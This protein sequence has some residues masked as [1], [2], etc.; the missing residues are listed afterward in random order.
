MNAQP[1]RFIVQSVVC[2]RGSEIS[3]P[4]VH[5]PYGVLVQ[6]K[7]RTVLLAKKGRHPTT[8]ERRFPAGT[9]WISN[10]D[11]EVRTKGA[12]TF[13]PYDDLF[14]A[15]RACSHTSNQ[16]GVDSKTAGTET[17]DLAR[18]INTSRKL[19]PFALRGRSLSECVR[20]GH[21][22][23]LHEEVV[24]LLQ[25]RDERKRDAASLL[26]GA[27]ETLVADALGRPNP[28]GSAMRIGGS[29]GML[30]KRND[31]VIL[32]GDIID[33]RAVVLHDYIDEFLRLSEALW[34]EIHESEHLQSKGRLWRL[35]D[36]AEKGSKKNAMPLERMR[37]LDALDSR[38]LGR[39]SVVSILRFYRSAFA[40]VLTRPFC[41][42]ARR[43]IKDLD[44][45]IEHC[46]SETL[47]ELKRR[48]EIIQRGTRWAFALNYLHLMILAP[49]STKIEAIRLERR[50]R[51]RGVPH[52]QRTTLAAELA[53][54]S[55]RFVGIQRE[56]DVFERKLRR[57]SDLDLVV[58]VKQRVETQIAAAKAALSDRRPLAA[59]AALLAIAGLL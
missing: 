31:L 8:I 43:L 41:R 30:L 29:I 45:A 36:L 18:N 51:M 34:A 55:G 13:V 12:T 58:P 14:A 54:E 9:V 35:F 33:S 57:C 15:Y 56:L 25:K 4:F 49:L 50:D 53:N 42:N 47:P 23:L 7:S 48:L 22:L 27:K 44:H 19:V 2:Y 16:Y 17:A 21:D 46:R 20:K 3:G 52:S 5:L 6:V 40:K 32:L 24:E 10:K 1:K 38:D 37:G 11:I 26:L 39:A 59:K 28:G